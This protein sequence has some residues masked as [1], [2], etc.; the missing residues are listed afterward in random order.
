MMVNWYQSITTKLTAGFIILILIIA[1]MS[2]LYT[3]GATKSALKETTREELT[4]LAT[5]SA[6]Q[7]DGDRIKNINPG[8]E[9]TS[10]FTTLRDQLY[11]IEKS[12][13][14]ILYVYLMRKTRD[15]VSFVIDADYGK[16]DDAAK[17]GD[18]YDLPTLEMISGFTSGNADHEFTTDQWGTVMSGYAPI[19]DSTGEIVG[20]IGIDMS[21]NKVIERQDFIGNTIYLIILIGILITGLIIGF[22]SRTMIRDIRSL[23]DSAA[24]ISCGDMDVLVTVERKDEIGELADS[25]SRMVASLKIM[26]MNDDD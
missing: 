11:R 1:G 7:I 6:T 12:S 25:F 19:K 18:V 2:V 5:L 4:A 17:I 8:D 23:N 20:I 24:R 21:A 14:E 26:M 22:F 15:T 13:P 10:R 3:L 16:T 9:S